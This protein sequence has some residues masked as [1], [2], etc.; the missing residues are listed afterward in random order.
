[1]SSGEQCAYGCTALAR[2]AKKSTFDSTYL[3][4]WGRRGRT[5]HAQFNRPRDITVGFGGGILVVDTLNGRVQVFDSYGNYL[6][7]LGSVGNKDGQFLDPIGIAA[8]PDGFV[9]VADTGNH[10][11]QKFRAEGMFIKS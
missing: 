8:S 10:R 3:S 7:P 5:I 1:M 2:Q 11:I 9:F 6:F 4:Q